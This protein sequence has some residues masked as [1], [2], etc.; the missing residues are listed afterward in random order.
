MYLCTRTSIKPERSQNHHN[1]LRHRLPT[2]T[3]T[4]IRHAMPAPPTHDGP[5]SIQSNIT[6]TRVIT[7][8]NHYVK[9]NI[10]KTGLCIRMI[11]FLNLILYLVFFIFIFFFCF[12]FSHFLYSSRIYIFFSFNSIP[13]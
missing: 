11:D 9:K 3:V 7:T 2:A 13:S 12:S 4:I 5:N 10:K 8:Y 6:K 1:H